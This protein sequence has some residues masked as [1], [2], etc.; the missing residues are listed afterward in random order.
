MITMLFLFLIVGLVTGVLAG[1]LGIGGGVITVPALYYILYFYGFPQERLMHVCI[2]TA[3]AAT[4][5]TSIGS[6]WS[7]YRKG[8]ILPAALKIIVPGLVIGCI[9][10]ASLTYFLPNAFL[11]TAFGVMALL[12]AIY[13]FFP[14]LPALYIAPHL[15]KS[16]ALIGVGVG[17]LSSLLGIGGGIFMVPALLGYQVHMRNVIATSS[18]GTLVTALVGTL[19]YLIIAWHK[20]HLPNTFGYIEIP[21]FLAIGLC[22]FF[23][24]SL[25]VKLAHTLSPHLLKRI[26]AFAL[27]LTACAMLFGR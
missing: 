24:T 17:C 23:T 6:T 22:S 18:A 11:R 20:P 2:A 7:H 9:I 14:K 1:L 16:L 27:G 8:S 5:L 25:G 4:C 10:G 15:N 19:A 26:F 21:A 12:L 3:L 13:F